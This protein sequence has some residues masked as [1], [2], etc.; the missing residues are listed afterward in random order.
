MTE[1]WPISLDPK[2]QDIIES[3]ATE[4]SPGEIVEL[5]ARTNIGELKRRLMNDIPNGKLLAALNRLK[6]DTQKSDK[7]DETDEKTDLQKQLDKQAAEIV[8]LR[9]SQ[10]KPKKGFFKEQWE[11]LFGE[12]QEKTEEVSKESLPYAPTTAFN[13][14]RLAQLGFFPTDYSESLSS[15][16]SKLTKWQ[17]VRKGVQWAYIG[18][19][20]VSAEVEHFS[21]KTYLKIFDS[22]AKW[23]KFN[24]DVIKWLQKELDAW[25]KAHPD[26]KPRFESARWSI[27]SMETAFASGKYKEAYKYANE[28]TTYLKMNVSGD[29]HMKTDADRQAEK[30]RVSG[31]TVTAQTDATKKSEALERAKKQKKAIEN[32]IK[33]K[34]ERMDNTNN[35]LQRTITGD[36]IDAKYTDW[37]YGIQNIDTRVA[38]IDR[39]TIAITAN[40]VAPEVPQSLRESVDRNILRDPLIRQSEAR[41]ND[42][43]NAHGFRNP[44]GTIWGNPNNPLSQAKI[45]YDAGKSWY[46]GERLKAEYENAVSRSQ[47]LD[48]M[49]QYRE[50]VKEYVDKI[51]HEKAK[52][53]A[54]KP[55]LEARN[56]QQKKL[57]GREKAIP[58]MD[59]RIQKRDEKT[60]S[61]SM[62]AQEVAVREWEINSRLDKLSDPNTPQAERIKLNAELTDFIGTKNPEAQRLI[63]ALKNTPEWAAW[64]AARTR[65]LSE[66]RSALNLQETSFNKIKERLEKAQAQVEAIRQEQMQALAAFEEAADKAEK[67]GK[68]AELEAIREKAKTTIE[69]FNKKREALLASAGTDFDTAKVT[70]QPIEYNKLL[71]ANS[72]SKYF[73]KIDK[74]NT[75]LEGGSWAKWM[76]L[77]Y[78]ALMLAGIAQIGMTASQDGKK[79]AVYAGDMAAGFLPFG[80]GG[81][82]DIANGI[83]EWFTGKNYWTWDR[84]QW[85]DALV[86]VGMGVIGVVTFGASNIVKA[87][88]KAD[89][90]Y[91]VA[92]MAMTASK[93]I[94]HG[95][96]LWQGA[97]LGYGLVDVGRSMMSEGDGFKQNWEAL[98]RNNPNLP[99]QQKWWY[100]V[101]P[102]GY[103]IN[104]TPKS[105]P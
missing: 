32:D 46:E 72:L 57:E 82:Y 16:W 26:Q 105:K 81:A 98:K 53:L 89:K 99:A 11:N 10:W 95:Y 31:E 50:D 102:N 38:E 49:V 4:L 43:R 28:V 44:D 87:A 1:K 88:A 60:Q 48:S 76:R 39:I 27:T 91:D 93:W 14:V 68:W 19:H 78:G 33:A 97:H 86:R 67:A 77:L 18:I 29:W 34:R 62:N 84:V 42:T 40:P 104:G 83:Y 45:A 90:A 51:S 69:G 63:Q 85:S 36:N 8:A 35:I 66:L 47:H 59:K 7:T 103:E 17:K 13:V 92:K 15:D 101:I 24:A 74:F 9:E 65:I 75:S 6:A 3:E 12:S 58:E 73:D 20:A 41:I 23:A 37:K 94:G 52:L 30:A 55:Q 2:E 61:A 5:Q 22:D 25:S 80:I 96:I 64:V 56:I 100:F 21:D 54:L 70:L 71:Q 79:A